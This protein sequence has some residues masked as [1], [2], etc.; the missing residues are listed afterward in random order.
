MVELAIQMLQKE[1]EW[2]RELER[3][4]ELY[5]QSYAVDEETKEWTE[6]ALQDLN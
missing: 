1:L 3:S 4:A 2:R 6:A 5:A